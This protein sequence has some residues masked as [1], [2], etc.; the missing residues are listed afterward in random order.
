MELTNASER[1]LNEFIQVGRVGSTITRIDEDGKMRMDKIYFPSISENKI[2]WENGSQNIKLSPY[3]L[4]LPGKITGLLSINSIAK[5]IPDEL[6]LGIVNKEHVL[7]IVFQNLK[8]RQVWTK[9]LQILCSKSSKD[10]SEQLPNETQSIAT[11]FL[12][13]F[14]TKDD[15]DMII[16]MSDDEKAK[17][18]YFE[19]FFKNSTSIGAKFI[20]VKYEGNKLLQSQ[21]NMSTF[22]E[23]V[24]LRFNKYGDSLLFLRE[25]GYCICEIEWNNKIKIDTDFIKELKIVN[26]KYYHS[27]LQMHSIKIETDNG[28]E[29]SICTPFYKIYLEWKEGMEY[30][31]NNDDSI[32]ELRKKVRRSILSGAICVHNKND[33][34]SISPNKFVQTPPKSAKN[35]IFDLRNTIYDKMSS[36]FKNLIN[37]PNESISES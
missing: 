18:I 36:K 14:D 24:I 3:V 31:S 27:L 13:N 16:K 33:A 22:K 23:H 5:D 29:Y 28:N 32:F 37:S 19:K 4:V 25:D 6:C 26:N 8:E 21:I 12:V 9:G 11:Q 20:I 30:L 15:V 10:E 35:S 2:I 34:F 7:E 1:A 17:L